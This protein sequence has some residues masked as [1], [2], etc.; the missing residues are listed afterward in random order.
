MENLEEVVEVA[1]TYFDNL[2][3][4]GV[5]DQMKECLNAMQSKVT[6]DMQDFLSSEFTVEE[7]KVTLFKWDQQRL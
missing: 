7:V 3:H 2:F 6:D 1:S 4:V 5:G